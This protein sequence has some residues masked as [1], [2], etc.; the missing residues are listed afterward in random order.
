MLIA[1]FAGCILLIIGLIALDLGVFHRRGHEHVVHMREALMWSAAWISLALCFNV[2]VYFLYGHNW[3]GFRDTYASF[4]STTTD[5]QGQIVQPTIMNGVD[6]GQSFLSGYLLELSL[7]MDNLFVF[8]AILAYFHVP[9]GQQHRVLVW[10]ILGAIFLRGV[11]IGLGAALVHYFDWI[12][13]AFGVLLIWT[14]YKM[15]K[16]GDKPID[17]GRN[18]FIRIA[19]KLY[20]TT[21]ELHGNKFFVRLGD[22]ALHMTPLFLALILVDIADVMF[23]I[24][25]IPAIFGVTSDTFI[26]FT[27]NMFAVMGLRS[28]YFALIG[29]MHRFRYIQPAIV[30]LLAYIGVKMLLHQVLDIP[31]WVSLIVIFSVLASGIVIS[32]LT[33]RPAKLGHESRRSHDMAVSAQPGELA[34]KSRAR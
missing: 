23:A 15:L 24:D 9:R 30:T 13:Y 2:G 31:N 17:P 27:S 8:A 21:T 7:S 32:L 25:S 12:F 3:L 5:V 34:G 28:M 20:P 10:G 6:A 29:L 19:R 26:V 1:F 11:M 4:L 14:A 22:G 33:D 16:S 18:I